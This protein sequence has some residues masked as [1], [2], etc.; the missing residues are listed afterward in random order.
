M[1]RRGLKST[2]SDTGEEE[3]R[4]PPECGR[5]TRMVPPDRGKP[6][7]DHAVSIESSAS[8]PERGLMKPIGP[9][10]VRILLTITIFNEYTMLY[11]DN[12][13]FTYYEY[14]MKDE[15]SAKKELRD[16]LLGNSLEDADDLMAYVQYAS[17]L[18]ALGDDAE[19]NKLPSVFER[20]PFAGNVAGILKTRCKRGAWEAV[21]YSGET[22][23]FS[24]ID[25]QDF[26]CF[27]L[28]FGESFP[29]VKPL[30]DYWWE[31][32]EAAE[33]DE[34][35]AGIL[36]DFLD[37]YPIPEKERLPVVGT[38]ITEFEYQLLDRIFAGVKTR[39]AP[40]ICT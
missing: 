9:C 30:F 38:P 2:P 25:A 4:E 39:N 35:A 15:T 31:A 27:Q 26:Y 5:R 18:A 14:A 23:A 28:R 17:R 11:R 13:I 3:K 7:A 20:S 34:D 29:M 12:N 33:L 21:E 40:Y 10:E 22:L 36:R 32:C 6:R 8:D 1:S 24:L 19:I 37:V 16:R